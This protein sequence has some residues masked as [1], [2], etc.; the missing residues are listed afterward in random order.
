ML[1]ETIMLKSYQKFPQD[2]VN[3]SSWSHIAGHICCFPLQWSH[4]TFSDDCLWVVVFDTLDLMVPLL[5]R[6]FGP[7]R[8]GITTKGVNSGGYL[9]SAGPWACWGSGQCLCQPK[10]AG[11]LLCRLT[12]SPPSPPRPTSA[13]LPPPGTLSHPRA[14]P[15]GH[16]PLTPCYLHMES[17]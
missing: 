6:H 15:M 4:D 12:W 13:V 17:S 7:P 9:S 1:K 8:S 16:S 3:I 5:E 14:T 2:M 10:G 11:R